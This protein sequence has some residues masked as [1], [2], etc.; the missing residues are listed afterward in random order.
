[1]NISQKTSLVAV[2]CLA[3]GWLASAAGASTTPPAALIQ[4]SQNAAQK[5]SSVA[6]TDLTTLNGKSEML[7][8][9]ISS[10]Q[11]QESLRA[12]GHV[13]LQVRLIGDTL[14]FTTTVASALQSI[15]GLTTAQA[16]AHINQWIE[17]PASNKAAS[18]IA[19]SLTVSAL[20][21]IYAP[22]PSASV[23]M[24]RH[25]VQGKT[26]IS[27]TGRSNPSAK[28]LETTTIIIAQ[29]SSLPVAGTLKATQGKATE[30]KRATF[31]AW[32]KP[33]SVTTPAGAVTLSSITGS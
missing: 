20:V 25:K 27:I 23:S 26:L 10:S 6:F 18:A 29:A 8:G 14:Y 7:S 9:Q 28:T 16:T 3:A 19:Q 24:V 2:A 4:S 17:I 11:S 32:G 15:L 1:M 30:T 13:V 33:V 12:S 21:N 5:A 31:R 22:K